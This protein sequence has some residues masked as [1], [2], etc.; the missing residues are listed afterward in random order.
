MALIV[1]R[2][3]PSRAITRQVALRISSRLASQSTIFGI[4]LAG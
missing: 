2:A 1:A 4:L 3:I